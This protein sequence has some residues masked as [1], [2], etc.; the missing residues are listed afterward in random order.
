MANYTLAANTGSV[1]GNAV[2]FT[3]GLYLTTEPGYINRPPSIVGI[4]LLP[5]IG[6]RLLWQRS[7]GAYFVIIP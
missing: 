4:I 2:V 1:A 7:D 3:C 5:T 6:T